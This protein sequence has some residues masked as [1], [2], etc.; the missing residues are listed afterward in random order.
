MKAIIWTKY[1]PPEVLQLKEV[2]KPVPRDNEVLIKVFAATV[3]PGDCE[4]RRFEIHIL[5]WLPLRLYFGIRKPRI[6][7]LGMEVAGEIESVGKDVSGFKIGDQ[8]FGGTG[9]QFGAYAEYVCIRDS[10]LLTLKPKGISYEEAATIPTGGLNALHYIRKADIQPGQK[11]LINGAGGCFG[12]YAV[13]LAKNLGSEVTAVDS[14]E[15]LDLLRALGADHVIDYTQEDFW[16]NGKY[17]DIIFDVVGKGSVSLAMKSLTPNGRYILA[18]PWV[19]PVLQG[20]WSSITSG[21][22][23]IFALA[24]ESPE[25]LNFFKELIDTGK[26]K[27]VIDKHYPLEKMEEA[28][29]YVEEGTKTGHVVI[30]IAKNDGISSN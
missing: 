8:V 10:G 14:S 25:D 2:E 20:L 7:I 22:K 27:P 1:G 28:H 16:K 21:K 12:T 6:P 30:I 4:I 3:T 11:M 29:R 15:K 9:F 26:V 13:Q 18:T 17:Y 19:I 23:F 24:K 5:F